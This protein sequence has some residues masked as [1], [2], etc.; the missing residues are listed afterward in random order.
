MEKKIVD[1]ILEDISCIIKNGLDENEAG[2]TMTKAT[3]YYLTKNLLE[4]CV[5]NG[6][7]YDALIREY[8]DYIL[9]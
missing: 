3:A 6:I 5:I 9:K 2:F 1:Y 8:I 7:I 4:P